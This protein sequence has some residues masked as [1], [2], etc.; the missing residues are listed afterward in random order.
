MIKEYRNNPQHLRNYPKN[1]LARNISFF[2]VFLVIT[3]LVASL[4]I[5]R[6]N[7]SILLDGLDVQTRG[8]A[9]GYAYGGYNS[10]TRATNLGYHSSGKFP[11]GTIL[12]Y[13]PFDL[14][15]DLKFDAEVSFDKHA[16]QEGLSLFMR[17]AGNTE[18]AWKV[19]RFADQAMGMAGT[20]GSFG[21]KFDLHPTTS[22]QLEES[23]S[24]KSMCSPDPESL[25]S[26][27]GAFIATGIDENEKVTSSHPGYLQ[28]IKTPV[29]QMPVHNTSRLLSGQMN[30]L[31]V[32]WK[33]SSKTMILKYLGQEWKH[34]FKLTLD[35]SHG[36][37]FA[38]ASTIDSKKS[39]YE[40]NIKVHSLVGTV[41]P[42]VIRF[43][44]PNP[45]KK[46]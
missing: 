44:L 40:Q 1:N 21:F 30:H 4:T 17:P 34:S 39:H 23:S 24:C 12:S 13:V 8:V 16:H 27:F 46:N 3:A 7:S 36:Y 35:S 45:F 29:E 38:V 43:Y 25:D 9:S 14:S 26:P 19:V 20:P 10:A 41:S 33:G 15:H 5:W 42:S 11:A 37:W 22:Q 32:Q 2:I 6:Q 18:N 31:L 28:V